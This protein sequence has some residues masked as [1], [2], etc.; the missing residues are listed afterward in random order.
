MGENY[1]HSIMNLIIA[2]KKFDL[3]EIISKKIG[4]NIMK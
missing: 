1:S 4:T 2:L 3:Y